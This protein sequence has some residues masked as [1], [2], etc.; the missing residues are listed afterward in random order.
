[1]FELTSKFR[2]GISTQ[3]HQALSL[4]M[5][6]T[7]LNGT[8]R[9]HFPDGSDDLCVTIHGDGVWMKALLF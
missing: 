8:S 6:E 2:F 9:P 4:N 7:T 3:P 5:I 1:M